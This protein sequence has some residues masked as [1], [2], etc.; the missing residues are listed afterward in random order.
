[1]IVAVFFGTQI[2][3]HGSGSSM[4]IPAAAERA[5]AEQVDMTMGHGL[6]SVAA[7]VDDKAEAGIRNSFRTGAMR[8]A[9]RSRRPSRE[10]SSGRRFGHARNRTLRNHE[11]VNRRLR[12]DVPECQTIGVLEKRCRQGF[13]ARQFFQRAS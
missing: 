6:S 10:A 12:R 7:V 2:S 5:S 9:V 3:D 1:V 8:A 13:R 4:T 11:D